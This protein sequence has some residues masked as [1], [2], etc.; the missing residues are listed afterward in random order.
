MTKEDYINISK[1]EK[2]VTFKEFIKTYVRIAPE[3]KRI[4][5]WPLQR[6]FIDW[7]EK[8]KKQGLK[9]FYLKGKGRL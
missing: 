8:C 2:K 3:G 9:P 1:E 5:L 6:S 7:L 4:E